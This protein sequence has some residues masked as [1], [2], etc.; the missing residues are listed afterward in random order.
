[1][2]RGYD[3]AAEALRADPALGKQVFR[4]L[5]LIFYAAAA[6]PQ[7][8]WDALQALSVEFTGKTLP[9]VSAWGSTETSPLATDCHFQA[10]RSG[11]IGLPVPGVELKLVPNGDKR[12]ILVRGPN[13]TP[14]Y[15]K[16]EAL[17]REAFDAEGFYRIGDAVRFA[18]TERPE[19]GLFFDG[20]VSEDFKLTSGTWVSVGELRVDGIS[21]LAPVAQDIVVTG[22]NLNEVCFLVFPNVAACRRIA[23]ADEVTSIR[24]VLDHPAIR[25]AMR[26]GLERLRSQGGGTSRFAARARL[27]DTPP[28]VD[29]GEITDKAYINQRAVLARREQDVRLLHG[30]DPAHFIAIG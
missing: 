20:R 1:V 13:V 4:N 17:T 5:R 26:S 21:A 3:M 16:N 14:G 12:E 23:G 11:N 6:L 24:E 2:P 29:Y 25:E 9:M 18:D 22:H 7:S 15:W 19:A 27:L 10:G 28:S 8:V 30:E